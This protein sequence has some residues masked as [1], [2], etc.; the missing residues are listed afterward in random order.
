MVADLERCRGGRIILTDSRLRALPVT[1]VF[2]VRQTD[3]A[4]DTIAGI[5]PIR[6]HRMTDW[7]VVL[8]PRN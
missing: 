4:L 6:L 3:A 8:S 1:A 2:D 7:L 5:L